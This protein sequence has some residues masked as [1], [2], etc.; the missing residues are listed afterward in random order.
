[1]KKVLV[2]LLAGLIGIFA[3]AQQKSSAAKG[4]TETKTEKKVT[5]DNLKETLVVF[6]T[7]YGKIVFEFFPDKAPNHVKN[8]IE[9]AKSGFYNGT[10]FHR[11]VPGFMIQGGDPNTKTGDPSSWGTGGNY[12]PD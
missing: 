11:V 3:F 9:L 2:V 6:E 12:G 4:A 10:K 1:M 7:D 5:S 8:F